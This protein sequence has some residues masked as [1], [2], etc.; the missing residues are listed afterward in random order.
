MKIE[1]QSISMWWATYR[2]TFIPQAAHSS[3]FAVDQCEQAYL[4]GSAAM[5]LTM[6]RLIELDDQQRLTENVDR[7]TAEVY[8]FALNELLPPVNG[9]TN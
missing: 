7:L 9:V 2:N 1:D 8:T 3:Q 4:A 5:I 6:K